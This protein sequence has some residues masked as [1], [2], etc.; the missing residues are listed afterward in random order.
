MGYDRERWLRLTTKVW[1][2]HLG[3]WS[4]MYCD[5]EYVGSGMFYVGNQEVSLGHLSH[6]IKCVFKKSGVLKEIYFDVL[7]AGVYKSSGKIRV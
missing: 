5:E 1:S 4:V 6:T 3:E 7:H 2:K